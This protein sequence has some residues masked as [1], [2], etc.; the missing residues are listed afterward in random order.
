[1][2]KR[3]TLINTLINGNF[4]DRASLEK[5]LGA[6]QIDLKIR[7]EKLTLEQFQKIADYLSTQSSF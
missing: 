4:G 6:L 7:G 1:M 5:M 3:K 2:Q